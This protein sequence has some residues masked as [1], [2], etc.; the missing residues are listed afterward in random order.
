MLYSRFLCLTFFSL[1][2]LNACGRGGVKGNIEEQ[3]VMPN[4]INTDVN[5]SGRNLTAAGLKVFIKVN[6]H[7]VPAKD[8][9]GSHSYRVP[10]LV[11]PFQPYTWNHMIASQQPAPGTPIQTGTV[12]TL[13]TGNHHGAGPFLPWLMSHKWS[14]KIRGEGRCRDCHTERYCLECHSKIAMT[15]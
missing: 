5:A 7:T 3:W 9:I 2:L 11:V 6:E 15:N 1:L 12:V 14:V 10:G 13:T 8:G 4:A